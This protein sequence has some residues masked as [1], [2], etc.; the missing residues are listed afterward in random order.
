MVP[1]ESWP[2]L[3]QPFKCRLATLLS[4]IGFAAHVAVALSRAPFCLAMQGPASRGWPSA[5][6]IPSIACLLQFA[7][8]IRDGRVRGRS[9]GS[10]RLHAVACG[11]SFTL[12][13]KLQG[14]RMGTPCRV[15]SIG[16]PSQH[17]G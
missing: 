8:W 4:A 3:R 17:A 5:G 9:V 2:V 15:L 11:V 12:A 14:A 1:L 13:S 16:I 7:A 6:R 10:C